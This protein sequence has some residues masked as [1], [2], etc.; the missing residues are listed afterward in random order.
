MKANY[1]RYCYRNTR[2]PIEITPR[3]LTKLKLVLFDM[4]GVLTDT[5][6]SWR[7]IHN[8][9]GVS[10]DH[11][12]DLYL[13][14]EIDDYEFIQRD[15][16]LWRENGKLITE[17]KLKEILSDIPV[18]RGADKLIEKLHEYNIETAIVSAGLEI[19]AKKLEEKLG[20]DYVYA[21]GVKSD[22][23][24]RLTGEGIVN[25]RLL[26]KDQAVDRISKE[27][28]IDFNEMIGIGNSCFDIPMIQRCGLGIAFNPE[29]SCIEKSADIIIRGKNLEMLLP[30]L[31]PYL[32]H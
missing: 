1:C 29:D 27:L 17:D 19:L 8:Y 14:G 24:G 28:G 12:V 15:V 10:N 18:M 16:Y 26:Y 30:V 6:S 25:V 2:P 3:R 32:Q 7:H 21:N 31:I 13:R 5:G 20:I 9:F 23:N 4:D 22:E 11:S